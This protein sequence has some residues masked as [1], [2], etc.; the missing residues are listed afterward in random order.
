[1]PPALTHDKCRA[2]MC[3]CCGGKAGKVK[4]GSGLEPLIRKWA[5]PNWDPDVI[6]FPSG[7][8][9]TCRR[10]LFR[11]EKAGT[12][13]LPNRQGIKA[14]WQSFLLLEIKVP[15]GVLASLCSCP[16]CRA[17]KKTIVGRKGKKVKVKILSK[18]REV[19]NE[20][21]K[22]K[23][24][25]ATKV[26]NTCYQVTGPGIDHPCNANALKRNLISLICDSEGLGKEQIS[27]ELMK[28]VIEEKGVKRGEEMRCKQLKGG[29]DL[30][31]TVGKPKIEENIVT[32]QTIGSVKK[33]LDLSKQDTGNSVQS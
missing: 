20:E 33:V 4:V 31:I 12:T 2:E 25:I 9:E 1:M 17:R 8:C 26:C 32:A 21:E 28:K 10:L 3:C 29:N 22:E 13:K 15:R 27:V 24:S 5:Q 7:I 6:S 18:E 23:K 11:C 14:K 16:I 19:A 30:V